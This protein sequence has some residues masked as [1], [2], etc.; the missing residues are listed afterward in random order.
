LRGFRQLVGQHGVSHLRSN[1]I[2]EG[3]QLVQSSREVTS[4]K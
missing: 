1:L 4:L 3:V 2:L